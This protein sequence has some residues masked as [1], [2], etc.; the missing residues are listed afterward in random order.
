MHPSLASAITKAASKQTY[1]TIR[2]LVDRSRME[3]AYRAYAYFRWVDDILD[4]EAPSGPG[5]RD[6]ERSRRKSFL[7][8]QRSLLDRCLRGEAPSDASGH[9]VMLVELVR[10]A[11]PADRG[12]YAYLRNMMQV[13][14]F[15]VRRRG[16][17]VTE[18]ELTEYTRW[19]ATAVT[20]AMHHFIGHDTAAP[21]DETR[22]LAASGAHILHMLRD[23]DADVRAG[24]INIPREVLEAHSIGPL[25]VQSAA[26]RT[27]VQGR[28]HL[29]RTY[30]DAGRAYFARVP[31][32]RHRIAGLAYIARFEWLTERLETDGFR[33][34]SGYDERRSV[35]TGAR[36]IWQVISWMAAPNGPGAP[37]TPIAAPPDG[38]A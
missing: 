18:V 25:D 15:D 4:A 5:G 33:L 34:R 24:Y 16:R 35:A 8:R 21:H 17:L 12:L 27:W 1:Y 23:T 31:A 13:M 3:D 38:P 10:R 7:D 28:V 11:D 30:L 6:P 26:Y 19:L 22:Y 9:E 2:V 14:E 37:S 32:P 29:A 36:M 20:E